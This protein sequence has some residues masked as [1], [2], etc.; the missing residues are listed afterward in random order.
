LLFPGKR[1]WPE[2]NNAMLNLYSILEISLIY[3][4]ISRIIVR[5]SIRISMK[6]LYSIYVI[7][8]AIFWL[9]FPN[10]ITLNIPHL[11]ALEGIM[12]TIICL[13]Y[14]YEFM[15]SGLAGD[16]QENTHF[17]VICGILFYFSTTVPFYFSSNSLLK[18]SPALR[19][20][21]DCIN[22]CFYTTL[23]LTFIKAYLCPIRVQK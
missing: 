3:L 11:F 4:F 20:V 2:I 17:I 18:I 9:Y 21:S 23:F 15:K 5:I 6:I 1:L 22:Y 16:I 13:L 8:C 7:F 10:A 12:I 14:F 19:I